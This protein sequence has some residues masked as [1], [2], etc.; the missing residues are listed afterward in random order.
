MTLINCV[1]IVVSALHTIIFPRRWSFHAKTQW[2]HQKGITRVCRTSSSCVY[3]RYAFYAVDSL[4]DSSPLQFALIAPHLFASQTKDE[5]IELNE[6]KWAN[7]RPGTQTTV[8][9]AKLWSRAP[10]TRESFCLNL[11]CDECLTSHVG[12]LLLFALKIGW[13]F[14]GSVFGFQM[15][16]NARDRHETHNIMQTP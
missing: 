12:R 14:I 4:F 13:N 6:E 9:N 3:R 16:N 11:F 5:S 10:C 8:N 7:K 15:D 1:T 2:R